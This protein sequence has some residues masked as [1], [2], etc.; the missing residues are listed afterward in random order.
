M[1]ETGTWQSIR[2]HGLLSTSALLD[3]FKINGTERRKIE[4]EHRPESVPITHE[5]HGSAVVRD[6]KP[7]RESAL[8]KC[9]QKPYTP[10]DWFR[11]LNGHVFFWLDS[12]RLDGLLGARAYRDTQHCVLTLDSQRL[13]TDYKRDITLSPMNSGSTIYDPLPRGP[14]TF[15]PIADFP[16]EK[17]RATRPIQNAVVE[18]LVKYAVPNV[19]N[20]VLKVEERQG[21]R[22]IRT[23][24][25]RT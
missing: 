18:L 10:M 12:R 21:A 2:R 23:I 5:Q 7:M 3:L 24:L 6:Q 15:L 8:L 20:Y 4:D 22:V 17:R 25:D 19:D 11:L 1:A 9:L 13:V 16:F 14:K